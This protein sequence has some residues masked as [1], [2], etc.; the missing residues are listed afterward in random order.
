LDEIH[1]FLHGQS[2]DIPSAEALCDW[3]QFCYALELCQEASAL[4]PYVREDEVDAAIYKRAKRVAKVC[5]S[6]ITG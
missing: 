1:A 4:L 2:P 3:I 5:R 6:K